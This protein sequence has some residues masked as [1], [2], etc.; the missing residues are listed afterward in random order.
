MA[1]ALR[2]HADEGLAIVGVLFKDEPE[3]ARRFVTE[4]GA[5][6]PT[7]LDPE[8]RLAAAYRVVAPPQTYFIDR[9]GIIRSIQ[10]GELLQEDLDRQLPAILGR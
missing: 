7:I 2:E 5:D 1:A 3:P 8:G 9:E 10:I 4:E 6:W